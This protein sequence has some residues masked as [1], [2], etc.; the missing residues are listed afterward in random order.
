MCLKLTMV[1]IQSPSKVLPSGGWAERVIRGL[2]AKS[3][4]EM[5]LRVPDGWRGE[6]WHGRGGGKGKK[7]NVFIE[8]LVILMLSNQRNYAYSVTFT[9][10]Y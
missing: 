7:R 10:N 4:D 5:A 6:G 8:M 2:S 1:N 9:K 3:W